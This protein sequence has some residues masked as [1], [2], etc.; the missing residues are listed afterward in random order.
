MKM[1]IILLLTSA[2]AQANE[3]RTFTTQDGRTLKA[4]VTRYDTASGTLQ[5]QREDGKKISVSVDTFSDDDKT[6]AAQWL[7]AQVFASTSQLKLDITREELKSS[8]TDL[9]IDLTDTDS[10]RGGSGIRN[11]GTDKNTQ[12]RFILNMNN[13]SA[14][15]LENLSMEYRLYYSQE[16]AELDK[17]A[18]EKLPEDRPDIYKAVNEEKVKKSSG[19][20]KPLE[21]KGEKQVATKPV[22]LLKRTVNNRDYEDKINLKSDLH[23]IWIK[24]TMRGPDG[25]RIVREIAYPPS[26]PGKFDWDREDGD[27]SSE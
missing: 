23:G 27:S 14:V 19:E 10:P 15:P 5:I 4:A 12:Y 11:I 9:E 20:L 25:E 16:K 26:I 8:K 1:L 3:F 13:S 2:I 6:Y 22:T 21:A 17:D 24:V 18:S 7:A